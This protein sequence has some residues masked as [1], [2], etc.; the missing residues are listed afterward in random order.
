MDPIENDASN[1]FYLTSRCLTTIVGIYIQTHRWEE[2]MKYAVQIG[3][4]VM[5]CSY[6]PSFVKI[7]L[8][9][10]KLIGGD[11]QTCRH[12]DSDMIS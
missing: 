11:T 4:G 6:I 5:I 12:T 7:G 8:G 3:L 2:F 1:N 9:I 10:Q